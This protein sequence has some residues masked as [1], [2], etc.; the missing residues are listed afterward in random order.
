M[1]IV[2]IMTKFF[3]WILLL[4]IVLLGCTKPQVGAADFNKKPSDV[5]IKP[6]DISNYEQKLYGFRIN[7]LA[8]CKE[9]KDTPIYHD[10]LMKLWRT[11]DDV[12]ICEAEDDIR[13]PVCYNDIAITTKNEAL[14]GKGY[15]S[16]IEYN[17]QLNSCIAVVRNNAELCNKI[18]SDRGKDNCLFDV[19]T[20]NSNEASCSKIGNSSYE[21]ES[22]ICLGVIKRDPNLCGGVYCVLNF[23]SND[24]K[25]CENIDQK[26]RFGKLYYYVCRAKI[27]KDL[28]ECDHEGIDNK[29]CK[30]FS[31]IFIKRYKNKV[32]L[33]LIY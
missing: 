15:E 13:K 19:G 20:V 7:S 23:A 22:D 8:D 11:T 10:C 2:I 30:S 5:F 25:I 32:P 26:K 28:S 3:T 18:S 16:S 27:K 29:E 6:N 33:N 9:F 24:L 1:F 4:S 17:D 12:S 14:C 21:E 31:Y